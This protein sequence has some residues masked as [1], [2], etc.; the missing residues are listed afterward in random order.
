MIRFSRPRHPSIFQIPLRPASRFP[1]VPAVDLTIFAT[2]NAPRFDRRSFVKLSVAAGALAAA[3][4][5]FAQDEPAFSLP[6]LNFAFDALEPHI[7]AKTMEIHHDKHHAGYVGKLNIAISENPDLKGKSLQEIVST[8]PSVA[9]EALRTT[10]RN[11]AGGHWNHS[12]FW[13]MLAP[14]GKGGQLEGALEAAI[15]SA[16]SSTDKFRED[17]A[18]A[19]SSRFGSGWAWLILQNNKLKIVSTPNQDNPLMK[20]IVPDSDLGTPIL[21]I[22]VWEHAYYLNYQNRRAE[23]IEAFWSVVNWKEVA[24]RFEAE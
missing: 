15:K 17:F 7:D 10:L 13:E 4:R 12:V 11:N 14:A 9:D 6:D 19:A 3:P 21:G 1:F 24:R 23:Y 16:F 8:L 22:D 2:M 18:A 20:G 5:G